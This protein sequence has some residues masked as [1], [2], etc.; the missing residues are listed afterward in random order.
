[1]AD[2]WLIKLNIVKCKKVS[3][4]RHIES[5]EHDGINNI[6]RENVEPI[7][8]LGVT[9]DSLTKFEFGLLNYEIIIVSRVIGSSTRN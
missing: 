6:E 7:K 3:F 5:T 2:N 4:G 1:L 8:D 9:F